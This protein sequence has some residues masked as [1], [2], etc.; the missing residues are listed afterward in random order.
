MYPS[1]SCFPLHFMDYRLHLWCNWRFRRQGHFV[2]LDVQSH[3]ESLANE[4]R[5]KGPW[6]AVNV[7]DC[8][9]LVQRTFAWLLWSGRCS[10]LSPAGTRSDIKCLWGHLTP[11]IDFIGTELLVHREAGQGNM[12][13]CVGVAERMGCRGRWPGFKSWLYYW[14]AVESWANYLFIWSL[15]VLTCNM[16]VI[17][18]WSVRS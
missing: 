17:S 1:A 5:G 16:G 11:G 13:P 15:N 3:R 9:T 6:I 2:P 10:H 8:M 12:Q 4:R 14:P 18:T 7:G